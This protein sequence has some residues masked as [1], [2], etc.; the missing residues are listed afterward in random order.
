M[1][2]TTIASNRFGLGGRPTDQALADPKRWLLQQLDR[3]EPRPQALAQVP[4]RADVVS[5]LGD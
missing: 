3:F 4:Q 1:Q 2:S 5:Q